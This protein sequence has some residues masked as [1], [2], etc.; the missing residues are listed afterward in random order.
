MNKPTL[1]VLDQICRYELGEMDGQETIDFFQ[2]LITTGLAW[3][4]Q[5]SYGRQADRLIRLG[6]CELK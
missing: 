1:S 5:G 4:L 3:S 2:E 6:L